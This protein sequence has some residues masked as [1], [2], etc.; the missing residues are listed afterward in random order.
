MV[1]MVRSA[2]ADA[3]STGDAFQRGRVTGLYEAVSL[4]AQQS[5]AFGTAGDD[6]GLAGIDP[7]RELLRGPPPP[8]RS[9][10]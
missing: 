10:A 4:L 2:K 9:A 7:E 3:D 8:D 5:D 1:D 6:T